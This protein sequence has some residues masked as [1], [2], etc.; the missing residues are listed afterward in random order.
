MTINT[1]SFYS[2][3]KEKSKNMIESH[4]DELIDEMREKFEQKLVEERINL[5]NQIQ[6]SLREDQIGDR[7]VFTLEL[8]N[9]GSK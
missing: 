3:L 5:L 8:K 2:V 7:I 1:S 6:Y 4:V 9:N